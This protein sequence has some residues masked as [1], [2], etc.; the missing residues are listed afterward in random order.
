[1]LLAA[2]SA[3]RLGRSKALLPH[4]GEPLVRRAVAALAAAPCDRVTVVVRS[5]ER[6]PIVRALAGVAAPVRLELLV[7]PEPERGLG[8]SLALAARALAGE[9]G[10]ERRLVALVDQP[11]ADARVFA[12][13]LE[14]AGAGLAACRYGATGP[15]GPPALF[16]ASW[17]DRLARL[18]GERGARELLEGERT[19]GHLAL[20]DFPGGEVDIDTPEDY[21]RLLAG[22]PPP[23]GG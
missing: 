2:G 17:L 3:R 12:A 22:A 4:A 6:L 23:D 16:P 20:V 8:S 19:S 11:L 9:P 10:L 13:L 18:D 7:H 21:A 5:S 15:I 14:A 1:M